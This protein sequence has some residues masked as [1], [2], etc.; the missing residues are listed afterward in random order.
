[1]GEGFFF[2]VKMNVQAGWIANADERPLSLRA[3][4]LRSLGGKG[5]V[6]IQKGEKGGRRK[7]G[8]EAG[9][10]S[11]PVWIDSPE[12]ESIQDEWDY[13]D[14][15]HSRKGKGEKDEPG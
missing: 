2:L 4:S 15:I 7:K 11:Y 1:M 5:R 3:R 6:F 10:F 9:S 14:M 13:I 8:R 12:R